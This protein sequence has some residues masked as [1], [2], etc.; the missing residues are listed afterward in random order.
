[1][2]FFAKLRQRAN[3]DD[4]KLYRAD[5]RHLGVV[6]AI[7]LLIAIGAVALLQ[8]HDQT[9]LSLGWSVAVGFIGWVLAMIGYAR[10]NRR[11]RGYSR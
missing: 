10:K 2:T 7:G 4:G 5:N 1:M 11:T 8:R 3:R 6:E 9:D